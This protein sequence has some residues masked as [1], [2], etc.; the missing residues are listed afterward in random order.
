MNKIH[1]FQSKTMLHNILFNRLI[2]KFSKDLVRYVRKSVG[3]VDLKTSDL[4]W[5]IYHL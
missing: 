4:K 3:K 1:P 5:R 2:I